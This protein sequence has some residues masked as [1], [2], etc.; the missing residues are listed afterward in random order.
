M[1]DAMELLEKSCPSCGEQCDTD[2]RYCPECNHIFWD[3]MSQAY[4]VRAALEHLQTAESPHDYWIGA[5]LLVT[6]VDDE[7]EGDWE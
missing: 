3:K 7:L 5:K 2:A 6:A 1:I 4:E